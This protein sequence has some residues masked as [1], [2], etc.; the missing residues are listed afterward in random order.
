MTNFEFCRDSIHSKTTESCIL[1]FLCTLG[2]TQPFR[3]QF[4]TLRCICSF[5]R[6]FVALKLD[7]WV[8]TSSCI[9]CHFGTQNIAR[10][11][12]FSN[13]TLR[14]FVFHLRSASPKPR[15]PSE[16]WSSCNH[17]C[18]RLIPDEALWRNVEFIVVLSGLVLCLCEHAQ[19][20][21]VSVAIRIQLYFYSYLKS[22][23]KLDYH[24]AKVKNK[25]TDFRKFWAGLCQISDSNSLHFLF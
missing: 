22:C 15:H 21:H 23:I 24:V 1:L 17:A 16:S 10:L 6:A 3:S 7:D 11:T 4:R 25:L 12:R 20:Q 8:Q 18:V 2:K 19:F 14:N 13:S 5:A 9:R